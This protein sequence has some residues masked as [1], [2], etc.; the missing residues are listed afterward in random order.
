MR[1]VSDYATTRNDTRF[2]WLPRPLRVCLY[3][4]TLEFFVRRRP[5][6]GIRTEWEFALGRPVILTPCKDRN[7]NVC[8]HRITI[9]QPNPDEL[10]V[11]DQ[12]QRRFGA[13]LIRLD[14]AIDWIFASGTEKQ[15]WREWL[16]KTVLLRW[17]RKGKMH[18]HMRDD[19]DEKTLYW[20]RQKDR[21][22]RSTRNLKLYDDEKASKRLGEHCVHLELCFFRSASCKA[23]GIYRP[24]D[25]L[26]LNPRGLFDKHVKL[27]SGVDDY[28]RHRVRRE[29]KA[30]RERHLACKYSSERSR[31]FHDR[32]CLLVPARVQYVLQQTGELRAQTLKDRHPHWLKKT[33][34]IDILNLPNRMTSRTTAP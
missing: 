14:F 8:G 12:L 5:Y 4:D 17:R 23:Q 9:H 15:R 2:E 24:S 13:L 25:I 29:V 28:L 20:I 11:L 18:D 22:R 27:V 10:P 19:G 26:G 31:D 34:S 1:F 21:A 30:Y 33:L 16:E 3:P 6:A 7:R 32:F